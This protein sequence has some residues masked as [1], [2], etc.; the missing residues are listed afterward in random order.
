MSV[1][2][3]TISGYGS[4]EKAKAAPRKLNERI[5]L[6]AKC[7]TNFGTRQGEHSPDA[8]LSPRGVALS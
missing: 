4:L 6:R 5:S 2:A 7:E 1:T 8:R 3:Q